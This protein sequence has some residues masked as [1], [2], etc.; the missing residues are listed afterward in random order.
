MDS[1]E[2]YKT[3]DDSA[4]KLYLG[5]VL[6]ECD[7]RE[8]NRKLLQLQNQHLFVNSFIGNYFMLAGIQSGFRFRLCLSKQKN[9]AHTETDSSVAPH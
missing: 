1:V 5:K 7:L 3:P 9:K 8:T 2:T 4:N 6:T